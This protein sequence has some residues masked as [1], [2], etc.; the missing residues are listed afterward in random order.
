MHVHLGSFKLISFRYYIYNICAKF[1]KSKLYNNINL[2]DNNS[3]GYKRKNDNYRQIFC[4]KMS[5]GRQPLTG[6]QRTVSRQG[7]AAENAGLKPSRGKTGAHDFPRR[8]VKGNRDGEIQPACLI[9]IQ[10]RCSRFTCRQVYLK[11]KGGVSSS[12]LI[13]FLAR[14]G[15]LKSFFLAGRLRPANNPVNA[16]TITR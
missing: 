12:M 6:R 11:T 16:Y 9:I 10:V 5:I 8:N 1:N 14:L 3:A 13:C 7:L 2:L 15:C 4:P